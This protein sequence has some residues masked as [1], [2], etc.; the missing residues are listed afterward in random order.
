MNLVRDAITAMGGGV[1]SKGF[2]DIAEALK[3]SPAGQAWADLIGGITGT[4]LS[5]GKKAKAVKIAAK[6]AP[7]EAQLN[8]DATAAYD[9][10]KGVALNKTGFNQALTNIAKAMQPE[11]L[12]RR[13]APD[14]FD[15]LADLMHRRNLKYSDIL[16]VRQ[17]AGRQARAY[18][19]TNPGKSR[20][21]GIVAE[22]LDK[23]ND[24]AAPNNPKFVADINA[25]KELGRSQSLAR[26][27]A[28]VR[29]GGEV[30]QMGEAIGQ[31]N[32]VRAY[33]ASRKGK[34]FSPVE[35]EAVKGAVGR[36]VRNPLRIFSRG[37]QS[38]LTQG[39]G[40]GASLMTMSPLPFL[41]TA[42]AG[43]LG[44]G[45]EALVDKMTLKRLD[46]I[47]AA[48]RAGRPRQEAAALKAA[49]INKRQWDSL[50]A[51]GILGTL[52]SQAIGD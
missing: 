28:E 47:Q 1:G 4:V 48:I 39:A 7:S 10:V 19:P 16:A 11:G 24:I 35:E 31:T 9:K 30:S 12:K 18:D 51:T 20:A 43:L 42:G 5:K 33:T 8:T 46:D 38:Y 50:K 25:A 29:R 3:A 15:D 14:L 22:Q 21:A 13:H 34:S 36:S 45:G 49:G 2:E 6:D 37:L 32:K 26:D 41:A 27:L 17:E 52:R 23:Y 44:R 40:F